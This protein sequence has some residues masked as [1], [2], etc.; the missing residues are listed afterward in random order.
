MTIRNTRLGAILDELAGYCLDLD[1]E[2]LA[3]HA[4]YSD[5]DCMNVLIIFNHV[6]ANRLIH[7]MRELRVDLEGG[8]DIA[9][10]AG[11]DLGALFKGRTGIDPKKFL[12]QKRT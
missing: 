1:A 12:K 2:D 10:H 7:K 4:E 11:E 5:E 3:K 9:A 6:T 8:C